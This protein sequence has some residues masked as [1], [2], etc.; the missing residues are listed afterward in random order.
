MSLP[1]V[2]KL[3][4]RLLGNLAVRR[5]ALFLGAHPRDEPGSTSAKGRHL[6]LENRTFAFEAQHMRRL[7]QR[8]AQRRGPLLGDAAELRRVP[9]LAHRRDQP[10]IGGELLR[11]REAPQVPDPGGPA[12]TTLRSAFTAPNWARWARSRG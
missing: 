4:L 11:V 1:I 9:A 3:P 10:R 12:A 8:R 7:H 5:Q 2:E 6:Y